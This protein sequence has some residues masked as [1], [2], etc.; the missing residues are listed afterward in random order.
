MLA[1][2][3]IIVLLSILTFLDSGSYRDALC[4]RFLRCSNEKKTLKTKRVKMSRNA[5]T[6]NSN[7]FHIFQLISLNEFLGLTILTLWFC[8]FLFTVPPLSVWDTGYPGLCNGKPDSMSYGK[9]TRT[10]SVFKFTKISTSLSTSAICCRWLWKPKKNWR[11][12]ATCG[13][14]TASI[15]AQMLCNTT[16]SLQ[17]GGRFS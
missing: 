8:F 4:S 9:W 15:T 12:E 7:L 5:K 1:F 10:W 17:N 13:H 14:Y 16:P 3:F 2:C 6:L 11:A